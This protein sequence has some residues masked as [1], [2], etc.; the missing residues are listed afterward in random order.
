V[1]K[2]RRNQFIT[3]L[4]MAVALGFFIARTWRPR[5]D[6]KEEAT[7]Q[8]AVY[9]MLDAARA[10]DTK[11]YL[12]CYT[13]AMERALRQSLAESTEAGFAKYLRDSTAAIKG[14]A[15]YD[16]EKVG[17]REAKLRVEFV[18][19]DRNETQTMYLEQGSDGWK[20][21]RADSTERIKTLIPYGTPVE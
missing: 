3:V 21:S 20:I 16:P 8:N 13:G 12:A 4:L 9:A 5:Q 7:P 10:G 1:T 19:Q 15:V 18:Y 2:E 17:D 14:T 11:A 6:A